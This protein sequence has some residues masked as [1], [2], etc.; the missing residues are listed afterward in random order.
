MCLHTSSRQASENQERSGDATAERRRHKAALKLR[1]GPA[2]R[3]KTGVSY[4]ISGRTSAVRR[5]REGW[6]LRLFGNELEEMRGSRL[7]VGGVGIERQPGGESGNSEHAGVVALAQMVEKRARV[8]GLLR[9]VLVVVLVRAMFMICR[10]AHGHGGN[11][12]V[13]L[14]KRGDGAPRIL[15][16]QPQHDQHQQQLS[17][18]WGH[19]DAKYRRIISGRAS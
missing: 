11:L 14:A 8:R 15:Q 3:E 9:P 13:V 17:D 2:E 18:S 12:G 1:G 7:G 16:G 19:T 10:V 4:P 6:A 5:L